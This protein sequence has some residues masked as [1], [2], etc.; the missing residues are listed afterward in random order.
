MQTYVTHKSFRLSC[1]LSVRI[2]LLVTTWIQINV[3][4]IKG[5]DL[6]LLLELSFEYEFYKDFQQKKNQRI[7]ISDESFV[8]YDGENKN[9]VFIYIFSGCG[10]SEWPLLM[11]WWYNWQLR[12]L[13]GISFNLYFSVKMLLMFWID[14]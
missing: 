4:Q 1:C 2:N 11:F 10:S 13:Q 8:D 14:V 9:K 6:H 3:I 12:R 7:D 5:P